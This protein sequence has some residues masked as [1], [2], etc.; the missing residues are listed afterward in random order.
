MVQLAE[1]SKYIGPQDKYRDNVTQDRRTEPARDGKP[2]A[3]MMSALVPR[4]M[5][6][7]ARGTPTDDERFAW[8]LVTDTVHR[9]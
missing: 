5:L 1:R 8:S 2:L 3:A 6:D 9:R 4:I 7:L